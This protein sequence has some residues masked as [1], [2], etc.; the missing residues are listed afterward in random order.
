M[1]DFP[2][3]VQASYRMQIVDVSEVTL[4]G[5]L[6]EEEQDDNGM[7]LSIFAWELTDGRNVANL[8]EWLNAFAGRSVVI[9]IKLTNQSDKGAK[10][11]DT[12]H[13]KLA[14]RDDS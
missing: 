4:R 1:N 12:T 8:T 13:A 3:N 6:S 5:V 7:N 11:S 10:L 9:T 14:E 2:P